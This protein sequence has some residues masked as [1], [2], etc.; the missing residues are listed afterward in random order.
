MTLTPV[1][2]VQ[3]GAVLKL[4]KSATG[5]KGA[6]NP[7]E[8]GSRERIISGASDRPEFGGISREWPIAKDSDFGSGQWLSAIKEA[9]QR[10]GGHRVASDVI[11]TVGWFQILYYRR[12]SIGWFVTAVIAVIDNE[13]GH[14]QTPLHEIDYIFPLGIRSVP[15]SKSSAGSCVRVYEGRKR[16]EV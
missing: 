7:D 3:L 5:Q 9:I 14:S 2:R 11:D 1:A 10:F 6:N 16:D 8:S 4:R 13:A 12:S 15:G